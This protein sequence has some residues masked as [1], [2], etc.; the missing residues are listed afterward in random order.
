MKGIERER[1]KSPKPRNKAQTKVDYTK[2]SLE[3]ITQNY[4]LVYY[5]AQMWVNYNDTGVSNKRDK[6][7]REKRQRERKCKEIEMKNEDVQFCS[8]ITS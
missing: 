4:R 2:S 8:H 1:V 6:R 7:C 5:V 3:I